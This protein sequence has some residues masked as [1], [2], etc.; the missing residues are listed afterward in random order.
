MANGAPRQEQ[1]RIAVCG[2]PAAMG[3]GRGDMGNAGAATG[4][5]PADNDMSLME[6]RR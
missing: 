5:K 6:R 1:K 2:S 3:N 4:P